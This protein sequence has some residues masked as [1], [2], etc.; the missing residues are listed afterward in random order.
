MGL[1]VANN[2]VLL[3]LGSRN[4]MGWWFQAAL[5]WVNLV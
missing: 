2:L 3:T 1:S 5:Q 4:P